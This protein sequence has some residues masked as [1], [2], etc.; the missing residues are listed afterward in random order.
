[1]GSRHSKCIPE[2]TYEREVWFIAGYEWGEH[3][4]KLVIVV[5]TLYGLKSS[6]QASRNFLVDTLKNTLGLTSSLADPDVW[7]IAPVK[8]NGE[9]YYSYL[10]IYVDNVI[11]IDMEPRKNIETIGETFKIEPGSAGSSSVYLGANIQKLSSRSGGDCWGIVVNSM[12]A[13]LSKM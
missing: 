9:K 5:R 3:A 10:L 1:M 12:F 13:M 6:G 4:G 8:S 2:Y 11:S 7:Y